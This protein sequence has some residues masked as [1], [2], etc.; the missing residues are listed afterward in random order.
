M[1]DGRSWVGMDGWDGWGFDDVDTMI[2]VYGGD[3]CIG[4]VG[5]I[6]KV[7]FGCASVCG[8]YIHGGGIVGGRGGRISRM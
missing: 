8:L 6:R 1:T 7:C 4:Y 3:I 5:G 2:V